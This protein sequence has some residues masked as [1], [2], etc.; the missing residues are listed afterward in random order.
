M[1][2]QQPVPATRIPAQIINTAF[3]QCW[4]RYSTWVVLHV[5]ACQKQ[6][7]AFYQCSSGVQLQQPTA[8]GNGLRG[9]Q[10]NQTLE[11]LWEGVV[12]RAA[13]GI[14]QGLPLAEP[15]ANHSPFPSALSS[16]SS[17]RP[18][19]KADAFLGIS[20]LLTDSLHLSHVGLLHLLALARGLFLIGR[21]K[22]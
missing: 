11:H 5:P 4:D 19:R 1:P 6:T 17:H 14:Q 15:A 7:P 8:W 2:S 21:N 20:S 10:N 3:L 18:C 16:W 13:R 12:S 22:S 9:N